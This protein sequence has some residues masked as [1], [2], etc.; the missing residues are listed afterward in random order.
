MEVSDAAG[1]LMMNIRG[2]KWSLPVLQGL[3]I[4][5]EI[6]PPI[7]QSAEVAGTI[8]AEVAELTGLAE[9]TPVVGGG[10]DN[11]C[12]AVGSGVVKQGRGMI[13]LGTSGVVLA[14]LVEPRL[15]RTGTVHM[16]NSCVPDEFYMMGVTLSAGLSLSWFRSVLGIL[17]NPMTS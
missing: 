1:M 6:L 15:V 8:T 17:R 4:S 9:G 3:Q 5:P 11:A 16:F 10:A 12:G 13:S 14:H 7:V 2:R